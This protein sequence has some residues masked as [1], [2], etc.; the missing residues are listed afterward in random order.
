MEERGRKLAFR[1]LA[2]RFKRS[3]MATNFGY[4]DKD[5]AL[6]LAGLRALGR[7]VRDIDL[8]GP[9]ARRALVPLLEDEDFST[10][11]F[12]AGYLIKMLPDRALAVL[13]A[14]EASGPSEV[15]ITAGSILR[16]HRLGTLDM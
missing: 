11:A 6:Q 14:V 5:K 15:R 1:L 2:E 13:Q 9:D 10:R 7:T 12:A 3:A 4:I 16:D 8:F